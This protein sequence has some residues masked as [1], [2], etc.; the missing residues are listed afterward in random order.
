MKT[1]H[2]NYTHNVSP[3]KGQGSCVPHSG[4]PLT[5]GAGELLRAYD[6]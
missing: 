2:Q 3:V 1:Q 4:R 6:K 5:T